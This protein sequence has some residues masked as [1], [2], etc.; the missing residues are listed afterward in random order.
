M[1]L[2]QLWSY[3]ILNM[4][5]I[6]LFTTA[7]FIITFFIVNHFNTSDKK[8]LIT[9]P[10]SI[11]EKYLE[12]FN[13]T[14]QVQLVYQNSISVQSSPIVKSDNT[15]KVVIFTDPFCPDCNQLIKNIL[16]LK[17][18]QIQLKF[19]PLAQQCNSKIKFK[20]HLLSCD[21]AILS[22]CAENDVAKNKES[23]IK[24]IQWAEKL[25]YQ[26]IDT[27]KERLRLFKIFEISDEKFQMCKENSNR[28]ERLQKMITEA[29]EVKATSL[30]ALFINGK[31]FL[32]FR[33]L[34]LLQTVLSQPN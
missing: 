20:G 25:D 27:I 2:A 13:S 33:N 32:G 28:Q 11:S 31:R 26:K 15:I 22:L 30:P 9:D 10:D 5:K 6:F 12:Q 29:A 8:K 17:N 21:L 3:L 23:M 1:D 14:I 24:L 16:E 18:I 19:F 4:K 34:N 7:F